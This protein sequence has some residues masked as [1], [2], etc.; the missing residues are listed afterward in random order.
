MIFNRFYNFL[1]RGCLWMVIGGVSYGLLTDV[2]NILLGKMDNIN[3]RHK[4]N[5]ENIMGWTN[6]IN[7]I[8][9][10]SGLLLGTIYE[11]KE[12]NK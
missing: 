6:Y 1:S 7:N 8:G 2:G 12:V 5:K 4:K 9:G 11:Y 10:Y 3:K